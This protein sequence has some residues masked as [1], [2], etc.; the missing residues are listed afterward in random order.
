MGAVNIAPLLLLYYFGC[1]IAVALQ[2]LAPPELPSARIVGGKNAAEDQFPHQVSLQVAGQHY[3][4]GSIISANY[5]VTAAHCVI[6]DQGQTLP[7]SMVTLRAGSTQIH[8]GGV[9]VRIAKII[10][11][12]LY[13]S[14]INDIALLR[15]STPLTFSKSIKAIPLAISNPPTGA[16]VIVSGWGNLRQNGAQPTHLQ[17]TTL[18]SISTLQ[19]RRQIAYVPTSVVCLAHTSGNGIC[20]GDSGGPAIYKGKLIGVANFII[21]ECGLSFPDGYAKISF[22]RSWL[23]ENSDL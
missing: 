9:L 17:Y 19:C 15:L 7:A 1:A 12:P 13:V 23:R 16:S 6:G 22:F 18:R 21:R 14:N 3:C 10:I 4:G 5:V 2:A 11:H 8:S 20:Y